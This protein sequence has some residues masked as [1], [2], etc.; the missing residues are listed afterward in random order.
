VLYIHLIVI[1][2][3]LVEARWRFA[4]LRVV[5]VAF[6]LLDLRMSTSLTPA[7]R[8]A[9]THPQ[10]VNLP[11]PPSEPQMLATDYQSG[12][13][14]MEEDANRVL[15]RL[16]FPSYVL[17]WLA[18]SPLLLN[19]MLPALMNAWRRGRGDRP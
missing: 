11:V 13:L 1:A 12:V 16:A 5:L 4:W 18:I 15:T 2:L 9:M 14:V 3:L 19:R 6:V 8:H 7:Y 10:R 17:A